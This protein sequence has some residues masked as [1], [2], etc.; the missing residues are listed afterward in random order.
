MYDK[1]DLKYLYNTPKTIRWEI[2]AGDRELSYYEAYDLIFDD[3][4]LKI[5]NVRKRI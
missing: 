1:Y 4:D 2:I 3:Y 5:R